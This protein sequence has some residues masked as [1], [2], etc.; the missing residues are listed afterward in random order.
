MTTLAT[1][2]A[3][4][5]QAFAD[6]D[7]RRATNVSHGRPQDAP[8]LLATGVRDV[9]A[10][11]VARDEQ[12][13]IVARTLEA[14]N[15]DARLNDFT[16]SLHGQLCRK[17]YLTDRQ[18]DAFM[19]GL[20]RRADRRPDVPA[21]TTAAVEE[22]VYERDG[23]VYVVKRARESGNLY[24]KRIVEIGGERLTEAGTVINAEF[25]YAPGAIRNLGPEHKM[26][27]DRAKALT[28]RYGFCIACGRHLKAAQSVEQGIGPICRGKFA[29]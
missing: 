16:G 15:L 2:A 26:P 3:A 6:L 29:A 18:V 4:V 8:A 20:A 19:R 10:D 11:W 1:R 21:P 9:F 25:E 14:D 5:E 22:G 23:V 24:A 12:H 28:I 13:A 27:L 17:G 7:T